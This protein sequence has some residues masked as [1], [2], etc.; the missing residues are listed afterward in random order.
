MA[1]S[2]SG[3]AARPSGRHQPRGFRLSGVEF[4][5]RWSLHILPKG[6]TK[7]RCDGGF[8]CRHRHDYLQRCRQLFQLP[9]PEDE[10][11]SPPPEELSEATRTCPRCQGK[12]VCIASASRR[13][14]LDLFSDHAT[15]PLWY[16]PRLSIFR[17]APIRGLDT[18]TL[19]AT[20]T[21]CSFSAVS[22]QRTTCGYARSAARCG[23]A[24]LTTGHPSPPTIVKT[25]LHVAS[26]C[27]AHLR[28]IRLSESASGA[29]SYPHRTASPAKTA[30][31]NARFIR[32]QVD[33]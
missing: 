3:P 1:K 16:Q 15:C 30:K 29:K 5:R 12:M 32:L 23:S 19:S 8:C 9:E 33:G 21:L 25:S 14:W 17:H 28:S 18:Q 10:P 6:F 24:L 2:R 31:F 20:C 26:A 13:S 7:T 27:L 22:A 4:V 11:P